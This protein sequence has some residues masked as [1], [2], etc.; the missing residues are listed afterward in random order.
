MP[1]GSHLCC[2]EI[3]LVNAETPVLWQAASAFIVCLS[4]RSIE[5][6]EKYFCVRLIP[7]NLFLNSKYTS[8]YV[9]GSFKRL[10]HGILLST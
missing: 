8:G 9:S 4:K 6:L 1:T 2:A 10:Y 3:E 7:N 5:L